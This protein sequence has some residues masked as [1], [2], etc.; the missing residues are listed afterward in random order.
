MSHAA[1]WW[2][3][4]SVGGTAGALTAVFGHGQLGD[5]AGRGCSCFVDVSGFAVAAHRGQPFA[6]VAFAVAWGGGAGEVAAQQHAG[7]PTRTDRR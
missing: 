2:R 7:G 4:S 1:T 5:F 6:G 3:V